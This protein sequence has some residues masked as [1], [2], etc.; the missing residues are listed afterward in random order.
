ML[1][2]LAEVVAFAL[3]DVRD[4]WTAGEVDRRAAGEVLAVLL[5]WVDLSGRVSPENWRTATAAGIDLLVDPARIRA[6]C[7]EAF[8]TALGRELSPPVRAVLTAAAAAEPLAASDPAAISWRGGLFV[9]VWGYW[10]TY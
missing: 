9:L 7:A 1:D 10:P 2:I 5:R 8:A 3:D 4:G 6:V